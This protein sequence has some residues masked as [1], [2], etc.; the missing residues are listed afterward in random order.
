[1]IHGRGEDPPPLPDLSGL[2]VGGGG[3]AGFA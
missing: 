3:F 1:M 2:G